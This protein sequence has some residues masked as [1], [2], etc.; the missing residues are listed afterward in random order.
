MKGH[1]AI[2]SDKRCVNLSTF[3]TF[4]LDGTSQP[5]IAG[6]SRALELLAHEDEGV[7]EHV[8]RCKRCS[9]RH[10]LDIPKRQ[11]CPCYIKGDSPQF[12]QKHAMRGTRVEL[13][14]VS[15]KEMV[16]RTWK[17]LQFYRYILIQMLPK[18]HSEFGLGWHCFP[19]F[20]MWHMTCQHHAA[21]Q[22][23]GAGD[24][25][26]PGTFCQS[27]DSS[28]ER[29]E[30]WR[31]LQTVNWRSGFYWSMSAFFMIFSFTLW[32]YQSNIIHLHTSIYYF[33]DVYSNNCY[34]VY[35]IIS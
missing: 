26:R 23:W 28:R 5:V 16:L 33:V 29:R 30:R 13:L 35:G 9:P 32:Q 25:G 10:S 22:A 12:C 7:S 19:L 2:R 1:H 4:A 27:C 18:Q 17:D 6:G 3:I 8:P 31:N 34:N 15:V 14:P 20:N 24:R 11:K 21:R